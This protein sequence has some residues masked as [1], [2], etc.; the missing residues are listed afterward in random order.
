[1]GMEIAHPEPAYTTQKEKKHHQIHHQQIQTN[2]A[3]MCLP[4]KIY[5]NENREGAT[6]ATLAASHI[7][8]SQFPTTFINDK[9]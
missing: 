2:K 3:R 6:S 4:P 8:H 9:I 7:S 1:M 5:R